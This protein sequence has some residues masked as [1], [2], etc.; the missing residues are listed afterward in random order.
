MIPRRKREAV[1][2]SWIP[3]DQILH[4]SP[5][6][7]KRITRDFDPRGIFLNIPYSQR[8]SKLEIAILSTVTAYDLM[9]RMAR[10]RSKLEMRLLKI[11]E[12]MLRCS[13]ALTD[14]SYAKRMNMPFEL[15]LLLA[16]GK[17]SFVTSSRPYSA[18]RTV[19]DLNFAD[20]HYHRGT[21]SGLVRE[22]S[23]WIEQTCSPKRIT[24]KTLIQRYRRLQTVRKRL[25]P[26]F[27]KLLPQE[28]GKLLEVVHDEFG[29]NLSGK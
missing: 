22:L 13:Y 14:L 16:F 2:P 24:T 9:P 11:V 6:V 7:R 5:A 28:I 17:E 15:G 21:V 29:M 25:G 19:S 1:I 12:L 18:L 3:A 20:I 23:K 26:D 27:E 8:Y 10:E 4:L